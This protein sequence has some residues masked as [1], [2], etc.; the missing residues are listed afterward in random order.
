[1]QINNQDDYNLVMNKIAVLMAKGENNLSDNE[2]IEL[3]ILAESAELWED[4]N[5][6][7]TSL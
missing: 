6:P 4:E 3:K 2:L 5:D 1:M 7:L